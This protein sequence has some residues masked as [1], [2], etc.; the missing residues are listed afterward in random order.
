MTQLYSSNLEKVKL[1]AKQEATKLRH[2]FVTAEHLLLGLLALKDCQAALFLRRKGQTYTKVRQ[3]LAQLLGRGQTKVDDPPRSLR[4]IML[5]HSAEDFAQAYKKPIGTLHLLWA[6]LESEASEA[7]QV[8][9]EDE[10][11]AKRW[12]G[13]IEDLLAE[14]TTRR[15]EVLSFRSK[16]GGEAE[17]SKWRKRLTQSGEELKKNIVV[18]EA[19]ITRI[20]DTLTRSWAG[21]LGSSR[22]I[23][24][25]LFVG[26]R[27]SGKLTLAR[28]IARFLF[29]DSDRV[30]RVSLGDFS[31]EGRAAQL[32]GS[33]GQDSLLGVL[34]REFP[35]G[36]IYF[37]DV[38]QAHP[39]AMECIHQILERGRF[40]TSDGQRLEFRDHIIILSLAIDAEFFK[41]ASLGFRKNKFENSTSQ[42]QYERLL[43]PDLEAVLRSDSL[44]L[45]DETVFFP[46][47]SD[48][49][50]ATLLQTW[51][52][53]LANEMARE[54]NVALK[55]SADVKT[56]LIKRNEEYGHGVSSLH[57]LFNR[58]VDSLLA[59]AL[60]SRQI[61][62]GSSVTLRWTGQKLT[63]ESTPKGEKNAA[64]P[65]E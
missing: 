27:G 34:V 26:P 59:K 22:P 48:K 16:S 15:P 4:N 63:L 54:H 21:F 62:R 57:R 19:A 2:E 28:N 65:K 40:M 58:E 25:F 56:Y 42:D 64:N 45:V 43:M 18:Q 8:L 49:D 47:I 36:V 6:I 39:K 12:R 32:L 5:F 61:E 31:D 11:E 9:V 55:V 50:Q 53:S 30:A 46:P 33:G 29:N 23:A 35:F 3:K 1:L 44:S 51:I 7:A 41:N 20:A 13:D 10:D 17:A 60:L 14:P 24:S 52:D 38:E 37:E